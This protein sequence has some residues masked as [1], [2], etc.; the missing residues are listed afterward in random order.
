LLPGRAGIGAGRLSAAATGFFLRL[1]IGGTRQEFLPAMLAAEVRRLS[2]AFGVDSGGGIYGHAA[3]R[4][5]CFGIGFTHGFVSFFVFVMLAFVLP[6]SDFDRET[7]PVPWGVTPM[8]AAGQGNAP[9]LGECA[10]HRPED[11]R[12][13][14]CT[15]LSMMPWAIA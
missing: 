12:I 9:A 1:C 6:D 13:V 7:V 14:T 15:L 4:V 10:K 2:I 8:D 11:Q 5:N 3:D